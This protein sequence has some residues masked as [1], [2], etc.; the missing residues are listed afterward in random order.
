LTFYRRA[1]TFIQNLY[2]RTPT[3]QTNLLPGTLGLLMLKAPAP[4]PMHGLE[5]RASG[6]ITR[7]T[8]QVK[9]GSLFPALQRMEQ[10]GWLTW[11]E[12]ENNR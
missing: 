7:G 9:P 6:Q 2:R 3:P 12:S 4:G 5:C 10:A 11:G 1:V 8:F